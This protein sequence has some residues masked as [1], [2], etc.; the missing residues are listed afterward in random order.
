MVMREFCKSCSYSLR[1]VPV[2]VVAVA[3]AAVCAAVARVASASSFEILLSSKICIC[4]AFDNFVLTR[5]AA[6]SEVDIL[7]VAAVT[8]SMLVAP[9]NP[10]TLNCFLKI[11]DINN[12]EKPLANKSK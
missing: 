10:R 2:T 11:Q 7:A 9:C 6:K 3:L 8:I 1:R 12:L 5:T 4:C